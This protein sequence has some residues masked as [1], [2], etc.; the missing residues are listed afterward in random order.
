MSNEILH[1]NRNGCAL[2]GA[3][4]VVNAID[5]LVPIIHSTA[6]CSIQSKQSEN[7]LTGNNG[8]F[9]RGW[10]EV[11]ATAVFEKQVVF[12]G[13]SRLREQIKNTVK[14]QAA[15]LY[16]VVSGCAPELVGDDVPAM[17]K[18]GQ[19][20]NFPVIAVG[21][22]GFKGNIYKGY[23]WTVKA[24]LDRIAFKTIDFTKQIGLVNILGVVPNQ[25]IF[26]EGNLEEIRKILSQIGLQANTLLGYD[27]SKE[28]WKK[29]PNA[30]LNIIV[31]PWG[32]E[33]AKQLE[34]KFGTPYL[35]FGYIPVGAP[36]TSKFIELLG[37]KLKISKELIEKVISE[38]EKRLT[39]QLLKLAQTYLTCDFQ[40]EIA[41]V[42]ETSNVLGISRFL[43]DS[44]G[45]INSL[46]IITDEP[47]ADLRQQI[48]DTLPVN[49]SFDTQVVFTSNGK[50]IDEL[51]L[52]IKPQV[53]LGS[54]LEQNIAKKLSIP[55]IQ[56]ASPVYDTLFLNHTYT[57]YSGAVTL[58]QDFG[59]A[60][61]KY[62]SSTIIK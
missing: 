2:H 42:G 43:Q 38:N 23:E 18:E 36:D 45:Q 12:G 47:D 49:S 29:V 3:L 56:I 4:K 22:P 30:E 19:D 14:V 31:S 55:L 35:Y 40:K 16:V 9:H 37:E 1:K 61:L 6:G 52:K 53:I 20:Q 28:N 10:R 15:D 7:I 62:N 54:S 46:V 57:G 59:G 13:S 34:T 8:L 21:T 5:G 39:Y 51:L 26:W 24:I 48:K 44:F 11:P 32:L 33:A 60:I 41:L 50:E 58:L 25:D 17:V 27:Q